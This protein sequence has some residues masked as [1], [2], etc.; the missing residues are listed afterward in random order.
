MRDVG[1]IAI[2]L[3][4]VGM[5]IG[6]VSIAP[7]VS[8][9]ASPFYTIMLRPDSWS[10]EIQPPIAY[11]MQNDSAVWRNVDN[12]ESALYH[13]VMIDMDGDGIFNGTEDIDSGEI[14][15]EC[16]A[17]ATDCIVMYT[18]TFNNSVMG[19]DIETC[20]SVDC[21]SES[22]YGYIDEVYYEDGN[23]TTRQGAVVVR[24]H[25]DAGIVEEEVE[26]SEDTLLM[27]AIASGAGAIYIG[28]SLVKKDEE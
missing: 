20:S 14:Y 7:T 22:V 1:K 21:V 9:H 5:F 28:S 23:I 19:G 8:A 27:I 16:E 4:V 6:L 25:V 24:P 17:N 12:N 3:L 10:E 15:Y 26:E 11:I 18:L 13:R 2:A